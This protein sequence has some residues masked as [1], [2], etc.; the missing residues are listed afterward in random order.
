MEAQAQNSK[1]PAK[2]SAATTVET[3]GGYEIGPEDLLEISVWHEKDLQREVLVKPDGW[4]TFP[5]IG[6]VEAA[7]KTSPQLENDIK[8]RLRKYMPDPVVTVTVKQIKGLKVFVIGKVGK[9]GEY[10][11][12][13]YV[14]VLQALTLAGGLTPFAK[15][16]D[17]KIVRKQAGKESIIPFDYSEVKRGHSLEQ[18][19]TLRS[20]DVIIV[21]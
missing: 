3:S 10:V 19:V 13:R 21:P 5:L 15:E 18:N 14:D 1:T 8:T 6:N 16:A 12:G 17:I 20:G 2:T 4:L 11:I 9:P 7:G